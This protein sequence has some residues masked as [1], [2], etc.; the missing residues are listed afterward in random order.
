MPL[1]TSLTR[2]RPTVPVRAPRPEAPVKLDWIRYR[3]D[4]LGS[5]RLCGGHFSLAEEAEYL[6]LAGLEKRLLARSAPTG[7]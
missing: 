6:H 7:L 2:D 4:T 1:L 5:A 3:L